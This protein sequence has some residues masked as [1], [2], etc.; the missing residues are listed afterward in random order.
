MSQIQEIKQATDIVQILGE[1]LT[2]QHAGTNWRALCPFHGEKSPSFFVNQQLQ[3]YK[4]FGCG[5]SGDVF[6]FLEKYEGMTFAESLEY[7]AERAGITLERLSFTKEDDQRKQLLTILDL[8]KEYYHFLLTQHDAGAPAREYLKDRGTTA[9]S[10]KVFQIGYSLD[11]WDGLIKY[12]HGKKGFALEELEAAGLVIRNSSGRYYDRFRGRIMF[13]LT[14]VRGRIVG[15]S[16]RVLKPDK[17]EAKYINTPETQL[18][19]KSQLLFGFSQLYQEIRKAN[20]VVIVEGEFDVISS[21]QVHVNNVVGVKGSALTEEQ[22][23]LLSRTVAKIIL[24]FDRDAA[25]I[26]ATKRAI[27]VARGFAVDLRVIDFAVLSK[28]NGEPGSLAKMDPDQ[29]ARTQPAIWRQLVKSSTSIYDFLIESALN[30]YDVKTAEG[31][32]QIIDE[33]APSLNAL[34]HAVEKEHYIHKLS[35]ALGVKEQTVTKDIES[36]GV[37]KASQSAGQP[38]VTA[39]PQPVP[40]ATSPQPKLSGALARREMLEKYWWFL[41]LHLPADEVVE[42][43]QAGQKMEWSQP[44]LAQLVEVIVKAHSPFALEKVMSKLA[45]DRQQLLSDLYLQQEYLEN[46]DQLDLKKELL[47]TEKELQQLQKTAQIQQITAELDE[48]DGKSHKTAEDEAR[49]EELLKQIVVLRRKK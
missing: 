30:L 34:T 1:R 49:Q 5:E 19:H 18:Y 45:E 16:G 35:Q 41:V 15:F 37:R 8:A 43:A 24:S 14:D 36:W 7:L 47:K 48:L 29:L 39:L 46:S 26:K 28:T 38:K 3:R 13:P 12:L 23:R 9:E 32:R 31:K 21:A 33:V 2:L 17:K 42:A 20:E 27:E 22:V 40:L 44:A 11:S 10:I 6:T 25:G 4:C